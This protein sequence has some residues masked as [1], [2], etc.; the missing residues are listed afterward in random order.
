MGLGNND[1]GLAIPVNVFDLVT[2]SILAASTAANATGQH[3]VSV[4]LGTFLGASLDLSITE[5]PQP[6]LG[7]RKITEE[8]I[9]NGDN[10]LRTAQIRLLLRVDWQGA[11]SGVLG[12]VN[13]LLDI[14][15]LLGLD[16]DLLPTYGPNAN[17]NLSVGIAVAP[18]Q[19]RVTKL[20]CE[21]ASTAD[22]YVGMDI[23]TG[24][25]SAHVGQI[26][27]TD[28]LSNSA[29]AHADPFNVLGIGYN[30]W[31]L[32]QP[33]LKILSVDLGVNLPIGA[34]TASPDVKGA[35]TLDQAV[36]PDIYAAFAQPGHKSDTADFPSGTSVGTTDILSN[37]GKKLKDA[38]RLQVSGAVGGLLQP[39]VDLVTFVAGT[40]I[41]D[42][43]GPLLDGIV[44]LLLD[45]LGVRIGT[46]EV[47][48]IDLQCGSAR[49]VHQ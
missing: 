12:L 43:L 21:P 22:R 3:P 27:P 25:A 29:P 28:F 40:L 42:V 36:F 2:A 20:G 34:P 16:V 47:A 14:V 8:D 5:Q 33:P 38:L 26:D 31:G 19:V 13:G 17:D 18:S 30:L 37:L 45:T 46:A 41:G 15:Q 10:I 44:D 9:R 4:S 1:A 49:L 39:I 6:P 7:F 23:D 24:L 35:D 48:V 32:I 11:L